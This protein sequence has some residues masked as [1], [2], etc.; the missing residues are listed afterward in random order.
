MH[1][2]D[3]F[4][5]RWQRLRCL[6]FQR[7]AAT[8]AGAETLLAHLRA[9]RT[10]VD[11]VGRGRRRRGDRFV[12][13]ELFGMGAELVQTPLAAEK[14]GLAG[15][16]ETQRAVR[17]HA[18]AADG[19]GDHQTGVGRCSGSA[20]GVGKPCRFLFEF[21]QAVAGAEIEG[22][23]AVGKPAGRLALIDC[24]AANRIGAHV[25]FAFL[26]GLVACW[27]LSFRSKDSIKRQIE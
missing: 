8:G 12:A 4:G 3:V 22:V 11:R 7:H 10:D 2:A 14:I 13:Q 1:R 23:I 19:I 20:G 16:L 5:L 6:G 17:L 18:H 27:D 26:R 24:H 25:A 21:I 9:H 15:V